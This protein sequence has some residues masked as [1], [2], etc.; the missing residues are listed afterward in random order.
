MIWQ[1]LVCSGSIATNSKFHAVARLA[2]MV[3][4][5]QLEKQ[6]GDCHAEKV[7]AKPKC[8]SASTKE[9]KSNW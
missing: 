2:P 3:G 5:R 6:R 7:G 4:K 8:A 1:L 9:C